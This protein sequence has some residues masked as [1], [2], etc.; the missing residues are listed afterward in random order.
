MSNFWRVRSVNDVEQIKQ[1]K[2][3]YCWAFDSG[4]L[5][6]LMALFT[7]DAVCELGPFGTWRGRA[8][9][10]RG[11]RS[12]MVASRVPGGRLHSVSNAIITV[13]G[14]HASGHWYLVDYDIEPG[15]TQPVRLLA[16]Y[17][18]TYRRDADR[19]RMSVTSLTIHRAYRDDPTGQR[20][21]HET[22]RSA[23]QTLP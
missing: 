8:D 21:G 12:Q 5:G 22:P 14:D 1:L 3:E 17:H 2:H 16:A 10:E 11:Y 20:P 18:D 13:D 9:I 4:D 23:G 6:R 7:D 15:T 19:W